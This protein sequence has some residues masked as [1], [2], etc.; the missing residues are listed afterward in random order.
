[1]FGTPIFR[2]KKI[3]VVTDHHSLQYL[4]TTRSASA[5]LARWVDEFQQYDLDIQYRPGSQATVPDALSR[6][7]DFAPAQVAAIQATEEESTYIESVFKFLLD[8]SLPPLPENNDNQEK[9]VSIE[10]LRQWLQS[11]SHMKEFWLYHGS[12]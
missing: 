5:R 3:T 6:R 7:P 10:N 8:G 4:K 2:E 1:M 11:P 12:L 9:R